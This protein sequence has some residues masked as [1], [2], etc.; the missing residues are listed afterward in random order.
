MENKEN[1]HREEEAANGDMVANSLRANGHRR[2]NESTRKVNKLWLWLGVLLLI[3]IL[4]YW[5]FSIGI[6]ESLAGVFNGN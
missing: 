2:H 1:L 3:A 6:M 5:L 4:L